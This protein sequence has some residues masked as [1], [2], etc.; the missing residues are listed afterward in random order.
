[1]ARENAGLENLGRV[2]FV[3]A[4]AVGA[5]LARALAERGADVVAVAARSWAHADTLACGLPGARAMTPDEVVRTADLVFLAVPDDAIP[6]CATGLPWHAE[7]RVV[8]LSGARGAEALSAAGERGARTAALHP[9]MTFTR[10]PLD[11]PVT[12]L[13]ARL[14]GCT[15]ALE[16]SDSAFDADLERVVAAL[17]GHVIRLGAADR[18]PYHIAGVLASN[19]A[20]ALLGAAVALWQAFGV[21]RADALQALLPLLRGTMENLSS[22]GLPHALSGPV[23]RGDVGTIAAHLAWL[24]AH[25]AS[26]P[27]L[28]DLRDGY[29][30]LARLAVPLARTKGTLAP[31]A[32][33]SLRSLLD[34]PT[35]RDG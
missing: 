35:P 28:A 1:M 24:D 6:A 20:V 7:Q 26:D 19:Y 27:L 9:L 13:L 14:D 10:A 18:V 5:T 17:G 33:E 34:P 30:A 4:G 31:A 3:G 15:W 32:A 29:R 12:T 11:T 23:A 16:V 22:A 2:G 21:D 8:H 25:A